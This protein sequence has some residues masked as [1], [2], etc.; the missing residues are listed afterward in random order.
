[1]RRLIA[2]LPNYATESTFDLVLQQAWEG[3]DDWQVRPPILRLLSAFLDANPAL[4]TEA[5]WARI[6]PF[7]HD[8]FNWL[9]RQYVLE[10][11]PSLLSVL[12]RGVLT[13]EDL[14]ELEAHLD[15]SYP[16]QEAG[17]LLEAF[18]LFAEQ[19]L[20]GFWL[21]SRQF[22]KLWIFNRL[23]QGREP[24]E[25]HQELRETLLPTVRLLEALTEP[26]PT[27]GIEAIRDWDSAK[28]QTIER[29]V[30]G[31][32][33]SMEVG[34]RHQVDRSSFVVEGAPTEIRVLPATYPILVLTLGEYLR[35]GI[36]D[37]DYDYQTNI[38]GQLKEEALPLLMTSFFMDL[39]P[40]YLLAFDRK[41]PHSRLPVANPT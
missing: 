7:F 24:A 19:D 16:S 6:R 31:S 34:I 33:F 25:L 36:L 17:V 12:G 27:M 8:P 29:Q 13:R 22:V 5:N 18:L 9:D 21:G 32:N 1:M 28:A 26:F 40:D 38:A 4:A 2:D 39:P 35:D 20:R 37:P 15:D 23:R 30:D 3:K 10:T 14:H 41:H 11:L